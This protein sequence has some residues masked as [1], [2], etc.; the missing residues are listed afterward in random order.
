[1]GETIRALLPMIEA[2]SDRSFLDA[3]LGKHKKALRRLNAYVNHVGKRSPMHPEAVAA[4]LSE[5]AADDAIF[6]ADTGMCNVWSSRYIRATKDRRLIGSFTHGSMANALPQA[7]GAQLCYPGRQ[8]IAMA[9]DG[10]L[11]MLMG[12][13]LTVTQYGLPIKI[14]VFNNSALG[15]VKLEMEVDGIPDYQ[16]DLKNPNFAKLAEAIGMMGVRIENPADLSSGLKQALQH[17]G[18]A[19]IDVVTDPNALSL[20]S[21]IEADQ[22]V[23]FAIAMGKL[24]LAGGID[25]VVDTIE[26][27]IRNI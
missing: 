4:A 19:L 10:G 5:I 12:D 16:T 22:V 6:T 13:L 2:K 7:I 23:G 1:M 20:P 26:T 14:V 8:V 18:P 3:M 9:G 15:M 27:N 24:V 11:A 25:E 21:H 17:S